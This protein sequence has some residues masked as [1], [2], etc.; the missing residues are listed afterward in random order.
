MVKIKKK[1]LKKK[2][3]VLP[4]NISTWD[5]LEQVGGVVFL[6]SFD[7]ALI[8]MYLSTLV[9]KVEVED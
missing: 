4:L 8:G 6:I 2:K 5:C 7:L 3:T 1:P 9:L